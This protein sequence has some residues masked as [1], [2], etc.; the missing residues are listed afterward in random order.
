[1]DTDTTYVMTDFSSKLKLKESNMRHVMLR[2]IGPY[3]NVTKLG[4]GLGWHLQQYCKP[5]GEWRDQD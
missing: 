5:V 2:M 3:P 1:M 4:C